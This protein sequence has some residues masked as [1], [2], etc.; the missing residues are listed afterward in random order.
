M[1]RVLHRSRKITDCH[2]FPVRADASLV[3]YQSIIGLHRSHITP[4]SS[5]HRK[6]LLA[7]SDFPDLHI[8][9]GD[10]SIVVT[11]ML[12]ARA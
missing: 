5:C 7:Q 1:T 6:S 12:R 8:C 3:S 9:T 4:V 2:F 11:A 10:F